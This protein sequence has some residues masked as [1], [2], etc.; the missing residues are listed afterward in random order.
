[1]MKLAYKLSFSSWRTAKVKMLSIVL[2]AALLWSTAGIV[3]TAKAGPV[4]PQYSWELVDASRN[5]VDVAY[6]NGVYVAISE[7]YDR[8]ANFDQ[9]IVST[10]WTSPDMMTWTAVDLTA[11]T[12]RPL[13]SVNYY[14]DRFVLTAKRSSG[15]TGY[16]PNEQPLYSGAVVLH[17]ING[18]SWAGLPFENYVQLENS[19]YT[20]GL[21]Y[22]NRYFVGSA[23]GGQLRTYTTVW[24]SQN[25]MP[26]QS[27][28][29]DL[30]VH[31]NKLF[32]GGHN[33]EDKNK[34]ALSV[35]A[36]GG[37]SWSEL[38]SNELA[39][40]KAFVRAGDTLIGVGGGGDGVTFNTGKP[41][42]VIIEHVE[43]QGFNLMKGTLSGP[44][45]PKDGQF[46]SASFNSS[47]Q[48]FLAL[49][50]SG[51]VY[52]SADEGMTWHPDY[53]PMEAGTG[54]ISTNDGD[55]AFTSAGVFKRVAS[56]GDHTVT[57]SVT[58]TL[59]SATTFTVAV[60]DSNAV[61]VNEAGVVYSTSNT[62]Q[63]GD[64]QEAGVAGVVLGPNKLYDV[65][66]SGLDGGTRYYYWPYSKDAMGY[67]Y[68]GDMDYFDTVI[69]AEAPVF[70]AQ[71]EDVTVTEG[72]P[73]PALSVTAAVYDGGTLTYQWYSNSTRSNNGGDPINGEVH[74][75]FTAPTDTV[76]TF[77]YYVGVTNTLDGAGNTTAYS[78]PALVTVYPNLPKVIADIDDQTLT[79]LVAGYGA[80][81]QEARSVSVTNIG[82]TDLEQVAVALSG[83]HAGSFTVTQPPSTLAKGAPAASF[84]VAAADGLPAGTYEAVVTITADGMAPVSFKVLQLINNAGAPDIP[85]NL[86]AAGASGAVELAW[87]TVTGA[88]YY[89]VYMSTSSMQYG[90]TPLTSAPGTTYTATGL[91]NGTTYY[92]VVRAVSAAESGFSNEA[93][94]TPLSVPGAP[95]DVTA[96]AG[97]KQV[98]LSFTAP[99]NGGSPI[100][101]YEV[102]TS[103][104]HRF[105]FEPSVSL[106]VRGLQNGQTYTFEVRAVNAAGPGPW[107]A[108]SNQAKPFQPE[109]DTVVPGGQQ[110]GGEAGVPG[111]SQDD[112][113][114]L[115][116]GKEERIGKAS[117][118]EAG[119]RTVTT[120]AVDEAQL[121]ERLAQAGQS[122]VITLPVAH[123][124]DVIIGELTGS[125]VEAL[126]S[127]GAVVEMRTLR[128]TYALPAAQIDI[129]AVAAQLGGNVNLQ[130][131]TLRIEIAASDAAAAQAI[132]DKAGQSGYEVVAEPVHYA[133]TAVYNGTSIEI[134]AFKQYVERSIAIADGVDP[135]KITTGV[136]LNA[137]G[138]LRHVPTYVTQQ[139]GSYHA[140]I[141]SL[142]NS[143]YAVVWNPLEFGDVESHWSKAAVN[144]MGSRLI[145]SGIADG[146]FGPDRSVTRAEFAAIVASGLGLKPQAGASSFADVRANDWF[147]ASVNA[148]T[149]HGLISGYADGTFRPQELITREQ[150][151]VIIAK[152]MGVTGL[153]AKLPTQATEAVLRP[154]TDGAHVSA[155]AARSV[156]DNV[157]AGVAQGKGN[158]Q[159]D[160]QANMTRA[161]AAALIRQLLEKSGLI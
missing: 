142:T 46:I 35:S 44:Y 18:M 136:V 120:L 110:G 29:D 127:Y 149:A 129:A 96:K 118:A 154:Y 87:D 27:Y 20:P 121:R 161:E 66:I 57:S 107:S 39:S 134:G 76:G 116:N 30:I 15:T 95:T 111:G 4:G 157:Q 75:T 11:L 88:T 84:T 124:S 108:V 133:V 131:I 7:V 40:I 150:A 43:Y 94:A 64:P 152:A 140:V 82:T 61:P 119:G 86:A 78:S 41:G 33:W 24:G 68:Y 159:L 112:A 49:S 19:T 37:A 65:T 34:L 125:M 8:N 23:N 21:Y 52:Y 59:T 48:H 70:L 72:D 155:W 130:D 26:A 97:N 141:N 1:M 139:G 144:D 56:F 105:E 71:P 73:G 143:D 135:G 90:M 22:N 25:I 98:R 5:F 117:T 10:V 2:I 42:A 79:G 60:D 14:N 115:V 13:A 17:W 128:G 81:T 102:L 122:P 138:T 91:T 103:S 58:G 123:D 38:A 85:Q 63:P 114:V 109:D 137:D 153:Q 16:Y 151:M 89:N 104:D 31:D 83:L 93:S 32:V 36:D 55:F 74:A 45:T 6:G 147:A 160:P 92:F 54:L 3:P 62:R 67:V 145:V 51:D 99:D 80:G 132:K 126:E 47:I 50:S 106:V 101:G 9:I 77:Y 113:V 100:T 69:P 156:A 146:L 158:G 12:T 28:P 148:A 53:S